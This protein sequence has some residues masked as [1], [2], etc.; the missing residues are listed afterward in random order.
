M[1]IYLSL[2]GRMQHLFDAGAL[3]WHLHNKTFKR[4][5]RDGLVFSSMHRNATLH[6][7]DRVER[8]VNMSESLSVKGRPS[9]CTNTN[10]L[11]RIHVLITNPVAFKSLIRGRGR[12]ISSANTSIN[13]DININIWK[14]SDGN[15]EG[16]LR[17]S[18][19]EPSRVFS[20][21]L[22]SRPVDLEVEFTDRFPRPPNPRAL[23][24]AFVL[25]AAAQPARS[26]SM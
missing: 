3:M 14:V 19:Q 4:K 24:S 20:T 6:L 23:L 13:M 12:S 22:H 21:T 17:L 18:N 25:R 11:M 7:Q 5:A 2:R 1:H 9:S 16:F 26:S 8:S 10:S 15:M